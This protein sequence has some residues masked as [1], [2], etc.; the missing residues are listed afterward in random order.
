[1]LN[2]SPFLIF[3]AAG[4]MEL[5]WLYAWAA[6]LLYSIFKCQI[7]F[8]LTGSVFLMAATVFALSKKFRWQR[9]YTLLL[10]LVILAAAYYF[11]IYWL[12]YSQNDFW[13]FKWF[14]GLIQR[15]KAPMEIIFLIVVGLLVITIWQRGI[16]SIKIPYGPENM[17]ARFDLGIAAFVVLFIIKL[18]LWV[19]G[20]IIVPQPRL[21]YIFLAYFI[22]SFV[23]IGALRYAGDGQQVF[24]E[25]FA[26]TGVLLSFSVVTVLIVTSLTLLFH[27]QLVEGARTLSVLLK[28]SATPLAPFLIMILRAI[29]SHRNQAPEIKP[30]NQA[31]SGLD[32]SD[33]SATETSSGI[34]QTLMAWGL[35]GLVLILLLIA[36]GLGLYFLWRYLLFRP[37]DQNKKKRQSGTLTAWLAGLR[38]FLKAMLKKISSLIRSPQTGVELYG[39]LSSWGRHSGLSRNQFETPLE[40]RSRLARRFP[41]LAPPIETIIKLFNSELYG[42]LS[43]SREMLETGIKAKRQL[44]RPIYWPKRFWTWFVSANN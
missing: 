44:C 43:L 8:S 16:K 39:A 12:R 37:A 40:Y 38:N 21:E 22:L 2:R 6:F 23:T 25:G 20:N 30:A 3:I 28:E 18:L 27:A 26:K 24:E 14:A 1:M 31:N 41:E 11:V 17:F 29:F 35:F 19:K 36:L 34:I 32:L 4:A 10:Q 15:P 5:C 13:D 33:L 7:S 42:G 9:I